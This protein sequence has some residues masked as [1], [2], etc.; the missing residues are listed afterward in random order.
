MY[1][2]GR[3]PAVGKESHGVT[4]AIQTNK[5]S[6]SLYIYIYMH[7]YIYIERERDR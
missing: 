1:G 7:I 4:A 2:I 3:P 6:L 5:L